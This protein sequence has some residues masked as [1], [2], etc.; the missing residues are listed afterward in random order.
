MFGFISDAVDFVADT[1]GDIGGSIVDAAEAVGEVIVDGAEALA[2]G[3]GDA[4]G[5]VGDAIGWAATTVDDFSGGTFSSALNFIDDYAFDT[6]DYLSGG[7]VDIDFDDGTFSAAVGID[8]VF[9]AGVSIGEHGITGEFDALVAGTELGLT[10]EG[11]LAETYGGIDFGPLPYAAGH[12]SVSD[13][14]EISINGEAQATIPTPIGFVSADVDGGFVKTDEGWGTYVNADGSLTL[15]SG[16]YVGANVGVNYAET[17]DGNVF[18]ASVGGRLGQIG[19]GEVG[20]G[21]E[22]DRIQQGDDV[23][24]HVGGEVYGEGYGFE[25]RAGA[26]YTAGTVDGVEFENFE[27]QGSV[28]GYGKS[29]SGGASYSEVSKD[30]VTVSAWETDFDLEGFDEDELKQLGTSLLGSAAGPEVAAV[31]TAVTEQGRL[32]DF[33]GALDPDQTAG[34]IGR[35]AGVGN[36]ASAPV[37]VGVAAMGEAG[38]VVAQGLRAD[39]VVGGAADPALDLDEPERMTRED[40][41]FAADDVVGDDGLGDERVGLEEPLLSEPTASGPDDGGAYDGGAYDEPGLEAQ[42]ATAYEGSTA[43]DEPTYEPEAYEAP[44]DEF[45]TTIAAADEVEASVD[46]MFED[47]G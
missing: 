17:A 25:A 7:L 2:D 32:D 3:A 15:P 6:V 5:Y 20:A 13:D 26:D 8:D 11:F 29:V 23:I 44:A 39:D 41:A 40:A 34:L 21:V 33:L 30:G 4:G 18:G 36:P 46:D 1:A 22:Y 31:L 37:E 27:A 47:L 12:M 10:D 24:E 14:G 35:L 42:E 43:Y 38:S 19:V 16:T 45:E 28:S 9:G